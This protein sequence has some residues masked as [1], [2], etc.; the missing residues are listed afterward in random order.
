MAIGLNV[1]AERWFN[2]L[3]A[4]YEFL[5]LKFKLK[6]QKSREVKPQVS[7]VAGALTLRRKAGI[8][9]LELVT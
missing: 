7:I 5:M 3:V 2:V 4:A 9:M 1:C 6:L 8:H